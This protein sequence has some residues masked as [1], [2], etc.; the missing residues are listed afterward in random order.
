MAMQQ[1]NNGSFRA[2]PLDIANVDTDQIIPARFLKRPR[3]D[4]YPSYLFHDLRFDGDGGEKPE[5]ILNRMPWRD[6]QVIVA[7]RNFGC[8]S[9]REGAVYALVDAGFR[10]VIAP[11]FGDIFYSNSM[12]NG[13]LPIRLPTETCS[14][15]RQSLAEGQGGEISIDLEGQTITGPDGVA[16]QF[17]I[18]PFHKHCLLNGLDDIGFT[19]EQRD[20]IK[21]AD[22]KR[23]IDMPWLTNASV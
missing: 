9:S 19:M 16:H 5:F 6:A 14:S 7:D 22:A 21:I 3:D 13:F 1:F 18:S 17:E 12:K 2:V 15:L 8:G 4:R 20:A 11:S 23:E 10:A